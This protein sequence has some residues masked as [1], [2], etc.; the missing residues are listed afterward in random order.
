M[1]QLIYSRTIKALIITVL[2]ISL[3]I[4]M[5]AP[6]WDIDI[7]WH[8]SQG[9]LIFQQKGFI[10]AD[11]FSLNGESAS[12]T[13][14]ILLN[15]YWI[16][17]VIL[18]LIFSVF[19]GY[20]L[21]LIR[22]LLYIIIL[23]I[24][25]CL[26][27]FMKVDFLYTSLLLT[28]SILISSNYTGV[29]TQIV[30]FL[31]SVLL[32]FLLEKIQVHINN[33]KLPLIYVI[34]LPITMISW[35][36]MHPGFMIGTVI[37]ILYSA[38]ELITCLRRNKKI[39]KIY[40]LY[41]L[42]M[43]LVIFSTLINPN[44]YMP[45]VELISYEGN[46]LQ[47]KTSE[48]LSPI[49]LFSKGTNY[50]IP[51]WGYLL[52][53]IVTIIKLNKQLKLR[54]FILMVFMIAISLRAFRYIPF[55]IFTTGPILAYYLNILMRDYIP[56]KGR[57]ILTVALAIGILVPVSAQ[58]Y[59]TFQRSMQSPIDESRYPVKMAEYILSNSLPSN[60]FNHF[61]WGGYLMWRLYP[62][63]KVFVDGRALNYETM[64]D[65]FNVLWNKELAEPLLRKHNIKTVVVPYSNPFTKEVYSLP[66]VL[67][68]SPNWKL[69]FMNKNGM[70][71][72]KV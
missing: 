33:N 66:K 36:N 32:I 48:Y 22:I 10:D 34:I 2:L 70:I 45:Y 31:F 29:R 42:L 17:D 14:E 27:T 39:E 63:Y 51:Y 56:N 50:L 38:S 49:T 54:H 9:K 53:C 8:L 37:I 25:Y 68:K 11:P 69:V 41:G 40:Y 65:Y 19:D 55:L 23:V 60:I 67:L 71:F 52:V 30:S 28:T 46:V 61:N 6:L 26:C 43:M 44:T 35:A 59:A 24:I 3:V 1:K 62:K 12:G 57:V 16:S 4:V 21:I 13:R 64:Y 7:W 18:Y 58:R 15:G 20:G 72:V 47:S 5:S